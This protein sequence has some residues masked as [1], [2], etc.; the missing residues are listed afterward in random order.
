MTDAGGSEL[1]SYDRMGREWG[2]QR[3]TSGVTKT[4]TYTYN[5][6]GSLSALTYPSGRVLTY[7]TDSAGRASEAQDLTNSINYVTGTCA[8]GVNNLGTCYTPPGA[9]ASLV[10]GEAGSFA[11]ITLSNSYNPRLEPS[12]LKASSSAGT[13]MDL[14]YSFVDANGH[15]NGNVIGITNNKDSTR[16]QSF[17]YDQV[18]R[19]SSA[20]TSS[21]SGSNCWG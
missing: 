15:N 11:G 13:A 7:T 3:T 4:T 21:T 17:A 20:Q 19:M 9:V 8:N 16:S 18:N 6:D 1:L 5:Y 2:E 14:V 12:E 10:L